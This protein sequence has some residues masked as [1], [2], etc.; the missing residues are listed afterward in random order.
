[1]DLKIHEALLEMGAGGEIVGRE[2]LSLEDGEIDLNL[3]DPAG[4]NRSVHKKSIGPA[5]ATVNR[6][7]N[8]L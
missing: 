5:I 8:Q 7:A 3:I 2:Y 4:M 6:D 1:M